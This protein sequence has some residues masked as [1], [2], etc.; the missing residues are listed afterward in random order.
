[1]FTGLI[2]K[3]SK[4]ENIVFNSY[5]AKVYYRAD[6]DDV[7]IGDSIAINGVCLTVTS[8]ERDIF[9]A[10]I[11]KETLNIS[12]LKNLKKNERVK[13]TDGI[14]LK[15]TAAKKAPDAVKEP[16]ANET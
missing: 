13:V 9:S 12:N 10:D 3:V 6:F 2:E 15:K 5:G 8:I 11:M 16:A 1:M 4:V 7:K 14:Q